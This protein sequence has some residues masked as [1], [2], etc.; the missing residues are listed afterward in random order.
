MLMIQQSDMR[1]YE[2]DAVCCFKRSQICKCA[3]YI[4]CSFSLFHCCSPVANSE[5]Y[6]ARKSFVL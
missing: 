5:N 3:Y 2:D 4:S 6:A 1:F